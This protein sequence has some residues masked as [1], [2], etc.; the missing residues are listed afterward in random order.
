MGSTSFCPE[1][2]QIEKNANNRTATN[3]READLYHAFK[4]LEGKPKDL[5]KDL[6]N[7]VDRVLPPSFPPRFTSP[8]SDILCSKWILQDNRSRLGNFGILRLLMHVSSRDA[9]YPIVVRINPGDTRFPS[10]FQSSI[11]ASGTNHLVKPTMTP[12]GLFFVDNIR[13]EMVPSI[14]MQMFEYFCWKFASVLLEQRNSSEWGDAMNTYLSTLQHYAHIL[15][16]LKSEDNKHKD[17]WPFWTPKHSE[18]FVKILFWMWLEPD[19]GVSDKQIHALYTLIRRLNECVKPYMESSS[20]DDFNSLN[21]YDSLRRKLVMEELLKPA[22]IRTSNMTLFPHRMFIFL[23]KNIDALRGTLV[24]RYHIIRLWLAW[25]KPWK[26]PKDKSLTPRPQFKEFVKANIDSYLTLF[27]IFLRQRFEFHEHDQKSLRNPFRCLRDVLELFQND[28]LLSWLKEGDRAISSDLDGGA[29]NG[30]ITFATEQPTSIY[31]NPLLW[32]DLRTLVHSVHMLHST[33]ILSNVAKPG[34]IWGSLANTIGITDTPF[35]ALPVSSSGWNE[36]EWNKQCRTT[37]TFI[38]NLGKSFGKNLGTKS[39]DD[40]F[41]SKSSSRKDKRRNTKSA[42]LNLLKDLWTHP[43]RSY[44]SRLL[45]KYSYTLSAKLNDLFEPR[46]WIFVDDMPAAIQYL[47]QR[48]AQRNK[49]SQKNEEDNNTELH[50]F[51]LI[52]SANGGELAVLIAVV[53]NFDK[54][55]HQ[56][57]IV[58]DN[59][60]PDGGGDN[61]E[62]HP[63]RIVCDSLEY[64]SNYGFTLDRKIYFRDEIELVRFYSTQPFYS[65]ADS[66]DGRDHL[67][68]PAQLLAPV[69]VCIVSVALTFCVG[70][71]G[72]CGPCAAAVPGGLSQAMGIR[73]SLSRVE[74]N[75]AVYACI[76]CIIYNCLPH[77]LGQ[78]VDGAHQR[79]LLN[80]FYF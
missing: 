35:E 76:C 77:I 65:D 78:V 23:Y 59:N 13:G 55:C 22:D 44:E 63:N 73:C 52:K 28:V 67:L 41:L 49:T 9:S 64:D 72:A 69:S 6:V 4:S 80:K 34:S 16:P 31:E 15:L 54:G 32:D 74:H 45:L 68:D 27:A 48:V 61:S 56:L 26:D 38:D 42:K 75:S 25:I 57:A 58:V 70:A 37:L 7:F 2:A 33:L 5:H 18:T 46:D 66:H 8:R 10:S 19:T 12:A 60:W 79:R 36:T 47:K 20:S 3:R 62:F 11:W 51:G 40:R 53:T 39:A 29:A 43:P 50:S 24:D 71:G 17:S 14:E 21:P 30:W 1:I